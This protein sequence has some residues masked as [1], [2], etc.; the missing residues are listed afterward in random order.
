MAIGTS[1]D[2]G[3]AQT[4]DLLELVP[5][6]AGRRRRLRLPR[7]PKVLIGL[8]ALPAFLVLAVIGPWIAPYNPARTF[9]TTASF[10]LPPSAAHLARHHPAAAGRVLPAARGRAEHDP[11]RVR[12]RAGRDRAVGRRRRDRGLRRRPGRRPAVDAG[13][14]LPGHAGPAAAHRHLRL[15]A[16]V[17][18][19]R[20]RADRADHRDHRLGLRRPGAAGA[21]AV[22]AQPG[23]RGVGAD[24]RRARLA[25]HRLRDPAQPD[26]DRRLVLPVHRALRRRHL[27]RAGLP[28]PGQPQPR[29]LGRDALLRAGRRRGAER[30]L[31]VVHPARARRGPAR[32]LRWRCSTS[33]S[34]SSSTRGCAPPG[35]PGGAPGGPGCRGAS[36]RPGGSC[37]A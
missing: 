11:G 3:G 1:T 6:R 37:S 35:C 25:D 32:H 15:P 5:G 29:E 17:P 23:L 30:V 26:P 28:R 12:G 4:A 2:L 20:R 36:A 33:A 24:H 10:P 19:Q 34:T 27:H 22:P 14:L 8:A 7:S 16:A 21:D 18:G 9:S 31:V 13:Q